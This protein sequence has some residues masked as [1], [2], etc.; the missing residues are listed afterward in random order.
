MSNSDRAMQARPAREPHD[1]EILREQW[2]LAAVAHVLADDAYK[3]A[4]EG[5][6]IFYSE[7]V[8]EL[9]AATPGTKLTTAER[10]ALT[11]PQYKEYVE[12]MHTLRREAAQLEIS[13]R[14][15]DRKYW[16]QVSS[17]ATQRSERRMSS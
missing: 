14:D 9:M 10:M 4:R 5:L 6:K 3:R 8:G 15:A 12:T 17:E 7:L 13:E 1:R 11:S 16:E 2:R